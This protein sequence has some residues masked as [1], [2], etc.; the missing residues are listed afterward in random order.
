MEIAFV[1]GHLDLS[2]DDFI[3]HYSKKIDIA[4][5]KNH[6]FVMGNARGCDTYAYRSCK[7][8]GVSDNKITIVKRESYESARKRDEY[9]T[10]ISTYNIAYICPDEETKKL[11]GNKYNSKYISGTQQNINHRKHKI[12]L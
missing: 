9:L 11:L 10:L 5:E 12:T 7:L 1:S 6:N 4:I 3:T 2:Y 8:K